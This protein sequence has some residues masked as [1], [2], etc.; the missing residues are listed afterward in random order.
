MYT[1]THEIIPTITD[2]IYGY[3]WHTTRCKLWK[4]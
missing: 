4:K 1:L 3:H 2:I